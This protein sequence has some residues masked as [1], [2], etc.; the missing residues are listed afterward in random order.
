MALG[1]WE[2]TLSPVDDDDD[3]L[4]VLLRGGGGGGLIA[5]LTTRFC[6]ALRFMSACYDGIA[7]GCNFTRYEQSSA[8]SEISTSGTSKRWRKGYNEI[9]IWATRNAKHEIHSVP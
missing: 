5:G 1:S 9:S 7:V 3:R 8:V 4:R 6:L 2:L